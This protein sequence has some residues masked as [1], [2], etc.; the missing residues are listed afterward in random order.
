MDVKS[1]FSTGSL[2][3]ISIWLGEQ[4]D[5]FIDH[6]NYVCK[7]ERLLYWL[8]LSPRTWHNT[9]DDYMLLLDSKNGES[10]H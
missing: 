1:R 5:G 9:I 8:K 3:R 10:D 4:L 6:P 7:L 2:T